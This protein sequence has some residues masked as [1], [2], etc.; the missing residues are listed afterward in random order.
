MQDEPRVVDV[1]RGEH[2]RHRVQGVRT[3]ERH[4][5]ILG[6]R[7][8]LRRRLFLFLHGSIR[9]SLQG[10]LLG[11]RLFLLRLLL[12]LPLLLL[13]LALVLLIRGIVAKEG[14]SLIISFR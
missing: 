4:Q 10:S 7:H 6:S 2:K 8:N 13:L 12:L 5:A 1:E 11:P 14:L 9:N 3:R